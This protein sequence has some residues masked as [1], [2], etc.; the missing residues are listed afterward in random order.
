[1][2]VLFEELSNN[3]RLWIYQAGRIFTS[4]EEGL[5]NKELE[6]FCEQWSAHGHPLKTSFKIAHH[7]FLVLAADESYHLPSG[8]SIDS[9]V[10]VIKS[11]QIETGID[12]FDRTLIA[13]KLGDEVKLFPLT[14]LKEEFANGTLTSE[15]LSFNNLVTTKLDWQNNWLV[16]VKDSWLARYLPKS[17]V[18][19]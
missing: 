5:I 6:A 16:P 15:T 14:K 11:L 19:S 4:G 1:M 7:Q 13:F 8:C 17:V 2:K 9:S 10:H 12:F 3:S 18:E